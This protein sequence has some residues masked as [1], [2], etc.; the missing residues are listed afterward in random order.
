MSRASLYYRWF[1]AL[2]APFYLLPVGITSLSFAILFHRALPA[3]RKAD[4]G[5]G[6]VSASGQANVRLHEKGS[7]FKVTITAS[8]LR[9]VFL[10]AFYLNILPLAYIGLMGVSPFP[11]PGY[12]LVVGVGGAFY[13][14]TPLI[15][16]DHATLNG[17][18]PYAEYLLVLLLPIVIPKL[19]NT[20]D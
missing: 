11:R 15:A 13:K 19:M 7:T 5:A 1:I 9:N 6:T 18:I 16:T 2:F 4:L 3:V 17:V 14:Q 10:Y 12:D 20:E 8:M